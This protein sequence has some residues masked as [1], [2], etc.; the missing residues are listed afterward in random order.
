MGRK[1]LRLIALHDQRKDTPYF[2]LFAWLL[3]RC[4]A[5]LQLTLFQ[6][7]LT[8]YPVQTQD[9]DPPTIRLRPEPLPRMRQIPSG[10]T[11]LG[12]PLIGQLAPPA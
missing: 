4:F 5:E 10:R 9:R 6:K 2:R 8:A 7:T 12:F 1:G 3:W 11:S